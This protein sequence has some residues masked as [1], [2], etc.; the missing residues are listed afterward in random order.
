[1]KLFISDVCFVILFPNTFCKVNAG[2]VK[3]KRRDLSSLEKDAWLLVSTL[4]LAT[5]DLPNTADIVNS[6]Y[7]MRNK[8]S[9]KKFLNGNF[10]Y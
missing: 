8:I 3:C 4:S 7:I 6:I 2:H 5:H 10:I 9:F 1:M